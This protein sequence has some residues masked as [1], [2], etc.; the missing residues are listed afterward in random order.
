MISI[1]DKYIVRKFLS[2]FFFAIMLIVV[3]AVIFD[4]TEKM[5]DILE[6][7]VPMSALIFEYYFNFIPYFANLFSPLF[8]FIAVVFFT[9]KMANQT[10]I[11]AILSSGMSF[12][13]LL[14]PYIFSACVIGALS[15]VLDSFIIPHANAKRLNFEFTYLKS[16]WFRNGYNV[17]R[18]VAPGNFVYIESY[19]STTDVGYR[20]TYEVIKDDE[21]VYKVKSEY[22]KWDT[23]ANIWRIEN[24]TERFLRD[25]KEEL[26]K[27]AA[28]DTNFNFTRAEFGKLAK[29]VEMM[30][31]KTLNAHIESEKL[32][33]ADQ[34]EYYQL[35]KYKRMANPFA[36]IIL[37][38]IA[39]A[40]A[41]RKVRGGVGL[42]IGMGLGIAFT[43]ILLMQI[44]SVFATAGGLDPMIAAWMPNLVYFMLS[45]WLIYKAPK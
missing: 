36:T 42:H 24:Y 1:I 39:A 6:K 23:V 27:G 44:S 38:L 11:V 18:Q 41:S 14:R 4:L 17:H 8:T 5:D 10:E 9:S 16:G 32:K 19:N 20:F 12:G 34:I 28:K 40:L 7:D 43:Y 29:E 13:R 2:T 37:T 3:I 26:V 30:D 25:G 31:M 21:L 45:L 15:F 22:L 35:V 33:G